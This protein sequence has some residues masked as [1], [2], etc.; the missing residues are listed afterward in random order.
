MSIKDEVL[1]ELTVKLA[2]LGDKFGTYLESVINDKSISFNESDDEV[3]L[4]CTCTSDDDEEDDEVED[5]EFDMDDDEE[6]TSR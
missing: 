5:D 1:A 4:S 6:S 2:D 3:S